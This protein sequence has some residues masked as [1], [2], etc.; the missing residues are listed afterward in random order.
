MPASAVYT[1]GD[2]HAVRLKR[3]GRWRER[4]VEIGL[5]DGRYTEIISGLREGDIVEA[6]PWSVM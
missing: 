1:V 4:L 6:N 5:T 2:R 3:D